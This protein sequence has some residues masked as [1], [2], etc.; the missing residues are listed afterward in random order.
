MK[1]AAIV[2]AAGQGARMGS[3]IPKVFL[4]LGGVPMVA[5]TLRALASVELIGEIV[6]VVAPAS[7]P[8]I[9][10][11]L[12]E[13]GPPRVPVHHVLGGAA[14]QDS[15]A[16]GLAAVSP[17]TEIVAVH[18]AARPFVSPARV[19]AVIEAAA[20]EGAALL[21]VPSRDT[22][23]LVDDHGVVTQTPPRQRVW[24]AQ[25]PQAFRAGLLREAHAR[26]RQ[27]GVV[28]T[29]DAALVERM[30]RPVKVVPG[31]ASNLKITTPADLHWAE[32]YL[33]SGEP[34]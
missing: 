5:V 28:A 11:V 6:V 14:R 32:W 24:L 17:E 34:R 4:P 27:D 16:A 20:A 3:E 2:V 13:S 22:V 30:G 31:D 18:D 19:T 1:V 8:R 25:T 29:D 7:V 21:A 33:R 23:K 10:R 12:Q 9:E 26:A 15:V